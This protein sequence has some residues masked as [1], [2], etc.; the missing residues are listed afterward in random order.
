MAVVVR[1]VT[2]RGVLHLHVV[3]FGVGKDEID[4]S[5]LGRYWSKTRGHGYISDVAGIRCQSGEEGHQWVLADHADAPTEQGRYVR[6]YLGEM[7]CKFKNV[8]E[9]TPEEIHATEGRG[10][11]KVSLMWACGL[12]VVSLSNCLH[13]SPETSN[14]AP[15]D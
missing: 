1:E 13:E 2:G 7:L 3:V 5:D 14:T 9:A 10:W 4:Q 12:P 6:A 15:T 8:A 11:W